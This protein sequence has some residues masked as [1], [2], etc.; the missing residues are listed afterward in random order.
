MKRLLLILLLC[1]GCTTLDSK[2]NSWVGQPESKLLTEWGSPDSAMWL[3]DGSKVFTWNH[4]WKGGKCRKTF[5]INP[6][7]YVE[8]YSNSGCHPLVF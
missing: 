3:D 6:Q 4:Y 2:M 5:T 8:K 1:A 7:G